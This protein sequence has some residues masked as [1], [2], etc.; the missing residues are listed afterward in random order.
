M[1]TFVLVHGSMHGGW[2]WKRV[3]PWL[4]AAGHHVHAP[5]LTG[6]GERAHLAH[7]GIDLGTHIQDIIG[8]LEYEDLRGVVLVGHS[9]GSVVVTGVADRLPARIAQLVYVDGA[10]AASG[11]AV[12]DFFPSAWLAARRALVDVEGGGWQLPPPADLSGFGIA[13]A[14]DVAW[15]RPRLAPQPFKTFTQ[16]LRL[17][18]AAGFAGPKTFVSCTEAPPAGWRDEMTR[19]ARAE[20][21]WGYRELATGHDAMITA[22]RELAGLLLEIA[23]SS[24]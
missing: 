5:T 15:V 13:D 3:V 8:V 20:R 4:H 11:Q 23:Q 14:D 10:E 2:C 17:E 6:L 19:R 16:P 18:S 1:A 7:P 9:Y 22:P 21:G 12:I 24:P